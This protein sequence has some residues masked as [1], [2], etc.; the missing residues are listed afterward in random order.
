MN[1]SLCISQLTFL[2]FYL[3]GAVGTGKYDHIS[4]LDCYSAIEVGEIFEY[5]ASELGSD[6]DPSIL[7]EDQKQELLG[8]WHEFACVLD[9]SRTLRVDRG[10]LNLVIAYVFESIHRRA[11][12]R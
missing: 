3:N 7:D 6:F 9:H 11:M 12:G 2:G 5:L 1:S 10:G 4:L 8:E